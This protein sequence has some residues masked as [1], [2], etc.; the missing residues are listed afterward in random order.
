M[1]PKLG[2]LSTLARL[3]NQPRRCCSPLFGYPNGEP[4]HHGS[5]SDLWSIYIQKMGTSLWRRRSYVLL[6]LIK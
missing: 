3:D 2:S 1:S 6:I 5:L 4:A